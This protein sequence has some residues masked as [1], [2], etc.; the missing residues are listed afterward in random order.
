MVSVA[1]VTTPNNDEAPDSVPRRILGAVPDVEI[2]VE[3]IVPLGNSAVPYFWVWGEDLATF[4]G[5]IA[6]YPEVTVLEKLERVDGG[7][8]YRIDWEVD[9]PMVHCVESADARIMEAY[10]TAERWELTVWFEPGVDASALLE[11]CRARNV[12]I[13]VDSLY[14]VA[15]LTNGDQEVVTPS[16]REALTLAYEHGY[17]E[18]PRGISQRELAS[19]LGISAA[20]LGTRLRRGTANLV[21]HRFIQ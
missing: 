13:E 18:Q 8:L 7:A 14:S 16:Q 2:E 11:C 21:E 1:V 4:E 15:N 6:G 3:R 12:P 20:A 10:G 5:T 19:Q 17:F 9:S